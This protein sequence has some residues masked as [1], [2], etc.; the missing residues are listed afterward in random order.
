MSAKGKQNKKPT[1][2]TLDVSQSGEEIP[3]GSVVY[4]LNWSCRRLRVIEGLEKYTKLR[5]LDLSCNSI[6]AI[7]GLSGC[8]VS[9]LAVVV[10]VF[11]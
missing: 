6:S 1:P 9:S 7:R 8:T 4:E 5:I 10:D 2:K 3:G 11:G